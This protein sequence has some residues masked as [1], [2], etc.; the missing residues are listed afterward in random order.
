VGLRPGGR[1]LWLER[2]EDRCLLNA[3]AA[4]L[5]NL[6]L[7]FEAN[8][9]QAEPSV[10]YLAHGGGYSLG[11][12]E[13]GAALTLSNRGQREVLNLQL[14]DA[15]ASPSLVGLDEQAGQANY[16]IGNDPSQWHIGVPLFGQVEYRQVYPGVDLVFYGNS[17]QQLEYDLDLAP[18]A[19]PSQVRVCFTGQQ[20]LDVDAAGDLVIHL[21]GGDVLQQAPVVFQADAGGGRTAVADRYV[22]RGDGTVGIALGGYDAGRPLVIDP[23]LSYSTYLG[24]SGSDQGNAVAVDGNGDA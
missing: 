13:Q 15:A 2:L 3:A 1:A 9:G 5:A 22:L 7:T 11:L 17:Q 14:V 16:L 24:G 18:D 6:P 10:R 23:V 21:A 12:S 19:D 20:G 4:D 8:Q